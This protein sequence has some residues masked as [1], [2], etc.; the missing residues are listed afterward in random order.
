MIVRVHGELNVNR[1]GRVLDKVISDILDRVDAK[2]AKLHD[3]VIETAFRVDGHEEPVKMMVDHETGAEPFTVDVEVDADG[4]IIGEKDN[5]EI[6]LFSEL[7]HKLLKGEE[8]ELPTEPIESVYNDKDLEELD[9]M[10]AG[11]LKGIIYKYGD[12]KVVKY[13]N[14][15]SLVA[16]A[17][18][19]E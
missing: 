1:L 9:V 19:Q 2:G 12:D 10:E 7:Y 4:N 13:Y 11:N 16:E 18:L 15:G 17:L 6:P 5:E 3:P 8:I 14:N